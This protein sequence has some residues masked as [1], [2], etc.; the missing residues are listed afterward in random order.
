MNPLTLSNCMPTRREFT[1]AVALGAAS[2]VAALAGPAPGHADES[3]QPKL[4]GIPALGQVLAEAARLRYGK[5][6]SDDQ[7]AALQRS[8]TNTLLGADRLAKLPLKNSD[9]PAVI[10]RAD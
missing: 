7:L 2:S 10:F 9:E 3:P 4:Q 8:V 5:H 6:L 1:R